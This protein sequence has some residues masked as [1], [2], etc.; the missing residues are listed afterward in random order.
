MRKT[1]GDTSVICTRKLVTKSDERKRK[2]EFK[3]VGIGDNADIPVIIIN[4]WPSYSR[5][6]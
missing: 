2:M 3:S 5:S 1:A 4:W 6:K